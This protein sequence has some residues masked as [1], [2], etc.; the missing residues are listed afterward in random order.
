MWFIKFYAVVLW[1]CRNYEMR[2]VRLLLILS[3]LMD[4]KRS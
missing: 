2:S 4:P 1:I 3:Q